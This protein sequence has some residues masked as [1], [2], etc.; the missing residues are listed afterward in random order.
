MDPDDGPRLRRHVLDAGVAARQVPAIRVSSS[1][2]SSRRVCVAVASA[3]PRIPRSSSCFPN[4][5][6]IRAIRNAMCRRAP[7][8]IATITTADNT[9]IWTR[10]RTTAS[11]TWKLFRYYTNGIQIIDVSDPAK[12]AFVSN[13][14]VPGQKQGEEDAYRK[15]RE[16]GDQ[17]SFTSLHGPM[18][19]PK[20]VE[21][22]GRYGYS[23]YGSFG[24]L[25]HDL[26]DIRNP[27]LVSRFNPPLKPGA[28]AFHTIDVARLDRGFV[29][30]NPE[31]LNPDCNEVYQP[32]FVVDI[33][34]SGEAAPDR[35]IACSRAAVR[36]AVTG[37][38]RQARTLRAAQ[39]AAPESTG[40]GRPEL[41]CLFVLQRGFAALQH[42]GS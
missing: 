33:R 14:W 36:C 6:A 32:S 1:A 42:Q 17:T 35:A 8:R 34:E 7:E 2:T 25:V 30:T 29:I 38:L 37:F 4:G 5:A 19:V 21:E 31:V 20:R 9:P 13:W 11:P 3:M 22:G 24:M 16:Y 10:D 41:H 27:K 39:S 12:P 18:Y 26:S 23:A 15:W 40:H 28:I